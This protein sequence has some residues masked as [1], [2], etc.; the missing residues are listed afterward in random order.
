MSKTYEAIQI[1]DGQ[2]TF[3]VPL[4]EILAQIEHGG[5]LKILSPLE[6]HTDRQRKWYKGI[7][8]PWLVEQDKKHNHE[9]KAWWD[10]EVKKECDGLNLLKLQYSLLDDGSVAARLTTVGVGKRKMTAFINEILAKSVEK[11]WGIAPPDE[12]LRT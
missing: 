5:A 2:P 6:Y 1:I 7:C 3:K 9:S 12:E 11:N 8:L 10:R 4:D